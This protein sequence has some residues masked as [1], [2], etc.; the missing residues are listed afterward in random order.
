MELSLSV[1]GIDRTYLLPGTDLV[2][3]LHRRTFQ[4]A[5]EREIV[6][7]LNQDTLVIPRHHD[8][9]LHYA[10]KHGLDLCPL[11]Y[12]Y[13]DTVVE[14]KLDIGKDR[15]VMLPE[16]IHYHALHRPRKP[17]L[18]LRKL[19][20]QLVIY[21]RLLLFRLRRFHGLPYDTLYLPVQSLD[22]LS[23]G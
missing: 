4:F 22:L 18:I 16:T 6:S 19:F 14:R 5:V 23:L 21:L 8:Y 2:P 10:V 3:R 11:G 1:Y 13:G 12:S 9:L 15:M 17:A 7:M 20:S